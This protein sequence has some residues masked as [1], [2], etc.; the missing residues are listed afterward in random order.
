M[1]FNRFYLR[2]AFYSLLASLLVIAAF[3]GSVRA[4]HREMEGVELTVYNQDLALVK[5]RRIME[6][7][8]GFG[9]LRFTEV[10][11]LIDPTSVW[12]R[13]L[14]E[15][16]VR[17]LEQNYKYDVIN[18]RKL[19][20]KYLGQKIRLTTVKGDNYE[21]YLI[22]AGANLI[23]AAKPDGGEVK[24]IKSEQLQAVFFPEMPGGL[25]V[26][27]TLVWLLSNPNKAGKQQVEVTYLTRG[28]SW[29]A[30]YVATVNQLEDRLDLIG[31]V[32]LDNKSGSE[33]KQAKLKLVAGDVN[34]VPETMRP[35]AEKVLLMR[36][37]KEEAADAGFAEESFFEYHLYVIL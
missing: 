26:R 22:G 9:E 34:R 24:V 25:V 19:L 36:A 8:A 33:Y 12:F 18:D 30:D 1:T 13:S 32:T 5:E 23:I 37:T 16:K 14:T 7:P 31:W 20:Q 28:L 11:A 15:P 4:D 29:K 10:A 17:V 21:G 6:L 2:I 3:N 35:E 27:P